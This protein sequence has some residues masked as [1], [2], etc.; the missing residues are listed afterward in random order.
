MV[1][2]STLIDTYHWYVR[3]TY[4]CTITG[5]AIRP[6]QTHCRRLCPRAGDKDFLD[7]NKFPCC[8]RHQAAS[9]INFGWPTH[10]RTPRST[11]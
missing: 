4:T 2:R 6:P 11:Q 8:G 10:L 3:R 5:I 1:A 9:S 7:F